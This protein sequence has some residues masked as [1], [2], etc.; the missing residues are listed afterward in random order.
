MKSQSIQEKPICLKE[1]NE[2]EKET[3]NVF[4]APDMLKS[5]LR[6]ANHPDK[7]KMP[8]EK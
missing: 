5:I 1:I 3:Q 6:C 7:Q 4:I 2:E 8:M